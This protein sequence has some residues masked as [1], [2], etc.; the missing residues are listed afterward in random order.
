LGGGLEAQRVLLGLPITNED[1]ELIDQGLI[2]VPMSDVTIEDT[3]FVTG[4]KGT[5][6]NTVVADEIFV[7]APRYV[8]TFKL[9]AGN[10]L[11]RRRSLPLALPARRHG[12]FGRPR[13]S[14]HSR[15][16]RSRTP[17]CFS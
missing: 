12:D 5:G 17:G 2:L 14:G 8:S 7:P 15:G 6:S 4:M 11:Q 13:L 10:P 3:W 16:R 1:G 9:L